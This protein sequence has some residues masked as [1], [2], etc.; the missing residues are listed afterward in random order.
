[1]TSEEAMINYNIGCP[2]CN[3]KDCMLGEN[4]EPNRKTCV[5]CKARWLDKK[6]D[7]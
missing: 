1:M 6:V 7:Y 2:Y 5:E 4:E 3:D